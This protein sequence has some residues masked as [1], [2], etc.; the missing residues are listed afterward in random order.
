MSAIETTQY[1]GTPN[2]ESRGGVFIKPELELE[3][4]IHRA[5]NAPW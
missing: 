5:A 1:S 4:D 2:K 3:L